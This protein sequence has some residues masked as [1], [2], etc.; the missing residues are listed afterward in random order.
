MHCQQWILDIIFIVCI[1]YIMLYGKVKFPKIFEN[2]SEKY[3]KLEYQPPP[4]RKSISRV[5]D[6][7]FPPPSGTL[8]HLMAQMLFCKGYRSFAFMKKYHIFEQRNIVDRVRQIQFKV[9]AAQWH[10]QICG[11]ELIELQLFSSYGSRHSGIAVLVFCPR[12]TTRWGKSR[13]VF[14]L[15]SPLFDCPIYI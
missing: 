13:K 6:V 3:L 9:S 14:H 8:L 7:K 10:L 2:I 11:K 4:G 1:I 5:S 15:I 12:A